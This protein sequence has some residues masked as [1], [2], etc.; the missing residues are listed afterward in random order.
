MLHIFHLNVKN[1]N[2][3]AGRIFAIIVSARHHRHDPGGGEGDEGVDGDGGGS[4]Q[5][6]PRQSIAHRR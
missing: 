6:A 2:S 4:G 5:G 3:N 1:F